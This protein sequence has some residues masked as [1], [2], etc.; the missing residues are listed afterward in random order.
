[1]AKFCELDGDLFGAIKQRFI[2]EINN[3]ERIK[4][5]KDIQ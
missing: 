3:Y 2:Q 1:M 4:C 5:S